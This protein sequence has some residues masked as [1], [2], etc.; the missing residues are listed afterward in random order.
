MPKGARWRRETWVRKDK[1]KR[2]PL[3][4]GEERCFKRITRRMRAVVSI[5]DEGEVPRAL[6]RLL[7]GESP[8][9]GLVELTLRGLGIEK[10]VVTRMPL[11]VL[12]DRRGRLL[13]WRRRP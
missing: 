8:S 5:T 11:S 9:K 4:R 2:E 12:R 1:R 7:K 6:Q 13:T 10:E 3:D